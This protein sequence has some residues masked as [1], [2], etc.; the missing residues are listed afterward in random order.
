MR[1][2]T[3]PLCLS[4]GDEVSR[5]RPGASKC[6]IARRRAPNRDQG[7]PGFPPFVAVFPLFQYGG[8]RHGLPARRQIVQSK[9]NLG[10]F[11]P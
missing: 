5:D 1:L 11:L 2:V 4:N 10:S 7:R 3:L 9:L 6:M 8:I